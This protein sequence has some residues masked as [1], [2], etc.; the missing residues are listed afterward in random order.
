[1]ILSSLL[2]NTS[3]RLVVTTSRRVLSTSRAE[4]VTKMHQLF[5]SQI[6]K[7][8]N[9]SQLYLSASIWFSE[10]EL[11]GMANFSLNE[12]LEER[13]HAL[14]MIDFGLKLDFPIDL[15]ALPA[16]H[17]HW[18]SIEALWVDLL[19]AEKKNSASL[20]TL[21]DAAHACQ[22]HALVTFLH[23]FHTEQ[24]N[25]IANLNTVVAK[26]KE[27]IRTPGLIR[28]LDNELGAGSK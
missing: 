10:K 2:Q 15:E 28:Q 14:E 12:S 5:N 13:T 9:A 21:A 6:T 8:M 27:E 24:V 26:V 17:A 25:G 7:E 18:S 4:A 19:E 16:P 11:T 20:Y 22:E 23:P 3:R 1:M